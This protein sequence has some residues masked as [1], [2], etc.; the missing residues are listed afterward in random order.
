VNK[1]KA[2]QRSTRS[3]G[4]FFSSNFF[5]KF[6][7]GRFALLAFLVAGMVGGVLE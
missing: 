5:Q 7:A 3:V 1:G 6:G 4:S 2:F